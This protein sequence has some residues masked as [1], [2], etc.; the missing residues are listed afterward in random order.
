MSRR[1][2]LCRYWLKPVLFAALISRHL[3]S[4]TSISRGE[5]FRLVGACEKELVVQKSRFIATA[6]PCGSY[7][8]AVE[9][10]RSRQ[11]R[12]ASHNCWAYCSSDGYEKYSDD[13]E[14]AGTAGRPI[15]TAIHAENLV[16][17]VVLV[18]RHFGGIKLGTGGLARAY[19]QAARDALR[20]PDRV[21]VIETVEARCTVGANDVGVVYRVAAGF[22]TR[23]VDEDFDET[24]VTV[25][26]VVPV[27][28]IEA[29]E[30]ELS[31]QTK[32]SAKVEKLS[33][34]SG[35]T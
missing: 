10:I 2:G 8:Q 22:N 17:V 11:D 9:L 7:E 5:V 34:I 19:G 21:P 28:E 23:K 12:K 16:D 26:F 30:E 1:Q 20:V 18:T 24:S 15:L 14:P 3:S 32:G 35:D 27:M 33:K 29:F 31:Q 25:K 4:K 13:G 6:A